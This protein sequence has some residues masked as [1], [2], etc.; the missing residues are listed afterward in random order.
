MPPVTAAAQPGRPRPPRGNRSVVQSMR[1]HRKA[2]NNAVPPHQAVSPRSSGFTGAMEAGSGGFAPPRFRQ[3]RK[4]R[5]PC[6]PSLL[7]PNRLMAAKGIGRRANEGS[8]RESSTTRDNPPTLV[9]KPAANWPSC[10]D[11]AHGH[12]LPH[13]LALS[14]IP[15]GAAPPERIRAGQPQNVPLIPKVHSEPANSALRKVACWGTPGPS[16]SCCSGM[17]STLRSVK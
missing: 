9:S 3:G 6:V 12:F 8:S 11:R 13:S 17:S 14:L 10:A 16:T 1:R 4:R 15:P 5:R 2:G 7:L